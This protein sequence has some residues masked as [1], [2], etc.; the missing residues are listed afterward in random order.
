MKLSDVPPHI[1]GLNPPWFHHIYSVDSV[2]IKPLFHLDYYDGPLSG[3]FRCLDKVF[4]TKAVYAADRKWWVA[5]ELS[6]EQSTAILD[7]HALFQKH[8]GTHTDYFIDDEGEVSRQVGAVRPQVEWEK[9]D[10]NR[11][12]IDFEEIEK[13]PFVGVL[14][15]PFRSW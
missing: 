11:K 14:R 6:S 15:N 7:N 5:W 13:K 4:Y 12:Q 3:I 10:S 9:F 1:T 8:V 2:D